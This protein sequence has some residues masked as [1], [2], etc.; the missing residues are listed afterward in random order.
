MKWTRRDFLR[1]LA[2]TFG[3]AAPPPDGYRIY[4]PFVAISGAYAVDLG[5]GAWAIGNDLVEQRIAFT[6]GGLF[7]TSFLHKASGRDWCAS[8][9]SPV[10]FLEEEDAELTSADGWAYAES[11]TI[12]AGDG[13]RLTVTVQHASRPI[14]VHS[15]FHVWS[16]APVVRSWT[17]YENVGPGARPLQAQS[18]CALTLGAAGALEVVW[19]APFSWLWNHTDDSF[20]AHRETLQNPGQ[21]RHL[22]IGPYAAEDVGGYNVVTY[23]PSCGWFVF[24]QPGPGA[25]LFGGVEW[26]GA[27]EAHLSLNGSGQG[28]IDIE[29]WRPAFTHVTGPGERVTSP[30]AFAGPFEGALDEA[31]HLTHRLAK[32]HYIPS[33]PSIRVPAGSEFPYVMADTWGYGPDIDEA[34]LAAFADRAAGIG[35]EAVTIDEG[36]EARIGDWTSHPARFPSGLRA[37]VDAIHGKSMAAG[38]WFAFANVDPVS[39]VA[40][41]HPD[42]LATQGGAPIVGSFGTRVLCLSHPDARA[43]VAAEFDRLVA[44]FDVDIFVQDFETIARCDDPAHAAWHQATDSEHANVLALWELIDG[45]RARHP[46]VMIENNWSGGRVM[47]FG[48]LR[49]YDTALCDDYNQAARNRGASFGVTH[50]FP[51]TFVSKYMGAEALPFDYQTRSYFFGGP[52]NL[53]TDLPAQDAAALASAVSAYKSIRPIVRDGRVVHLVAPSFSGSGGNRYQISWD[54]IQAVEPGANRAVLLI[55]RGLAGPETYN[56]KPQGLNP[57]KVYALAASSGANYGSRS[58]ADL[59]ANGIDVSLPERAHETIV[60]A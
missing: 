60:L 39:A 47:D 1:A 46:N 40:Q 23:R 16:D 49:R 13:A 48:M 58:G 28:R 41:A 36:W 3:A 27:C 12:S 44:E 21:E 51:P 25:G 42:W 14:R 59:M 50:F 17:E 37:S 22:V 30:V 31:A 15:H 38:L 43:W 6:G 19:I 54:A 9:V 35:V 4:L 2:V 56:V 57:A 10:F 26:S 18:F 34:G 7:T 5:G 45:V 20:V 11:A 29:H 8:A 32:T 33:R 53:M 24:H 52:W 55:G